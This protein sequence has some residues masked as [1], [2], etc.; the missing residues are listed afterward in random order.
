MVAPATA[1]LGSAHVCLMLSVRSVTCP[2]LDTGT[3]QKTLAVNRATATQKA[4]SASTVTSLP[5][6]ASVSPVEADVPV[7]SVKICTTGIPPSSATHVTVTPRAQ[8]RSSVTDE[9][10]S[11]C[12]GSVLV[13]SSVTGVT[14]GQ[15]VNCRTVC[16]VGTALITG[17][18]LSEA[19]EVRAAP[20]CKL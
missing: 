9:R 7:V 1:E 12:A 4:P 16:H 14:E 6:S 3:C 18:G 20:H 11:V 2:P 17:T 19:L 15:L 10:V 5:D 13:G 8:P